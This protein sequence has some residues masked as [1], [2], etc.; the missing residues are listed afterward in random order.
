MTNQKGHF[1]SQEALIVGFALNPSICFQ[2]PRWHG[3]ARLRAD[4]LQQ[5]QPSLA[6]IKGRSYLPLVISVTSFFFFC[7]S[8]GHLCSKSTCNKTKM[9]LSVFEEKNQN[10][11]QHA[12]SCAHTHTHTG[13]VEHKTKVKDISL[14]R[15]SACHGDSWSFTIASFQAATKKQKYEKISEKKMSTPVEVLC[16]VR[17]WNN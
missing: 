14:R 10:C 12:H 11:S 2:S 8:V 6:G 9:L 4:V 7:K 3:V 17:M 1:D 5:N 16:K 15:Y 13:H